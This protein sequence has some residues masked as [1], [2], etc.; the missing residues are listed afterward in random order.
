MHNE[1][2][3]R[4]EDSSKVETVRPSR[5]GVGVKTSSLKTKKKQKKQTNK[6]TNKQSVVVDCHLVEEGGPWPYRII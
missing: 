5:R 6:Q 1:G 2:Q 3:R 4:R